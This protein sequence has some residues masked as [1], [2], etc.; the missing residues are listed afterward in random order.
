M[1]NKERFSPQ[2]QPPPPYRYHA[3]T[4]ACFGKVHSIRQGGAKPAERGFLHHRLLNT[5]VTRMNK[6]LSDSD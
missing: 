1:R 3:N 6:D 5:D 2:H 4:P